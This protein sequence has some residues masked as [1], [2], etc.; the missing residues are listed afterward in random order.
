M[1]ELH[2]KSQTTFEDLPNEIFYEIFDYLDAI[3]LFRSFSN[4]NTRVQNLLGNSSLLLKV[5]ISSMSK[6]NF[7]DYKK[8]IILPCKH[9]IIS[10]NI[11]N[12]FVVDIM[13]RPVR[14]ASQLTRL[15]TVILDNIKSKY[16]CNI[17]KHLA[18]LRNLSSLVLIPIDHYRNTDEIYQC[19]FRLPV[20]KYCKISLKT[21]YRDGLLPIATNITSSIE[22]LVIQHSFYLKD[23]NALLSYVPHVRRLKFHSFHG[24]H[25]N[26]QEIFSCSSSKLTHLS[27]N[28]KS[29]SFDQFELMTQTL[30][31]QLDIIHISVDDDRTYLDAKRWENLILSF[32]PRLRVFDFQ[33]ID[34]IKNIAVDIQSIHEPLLKQFESSFW[35]QRKWF[36]HYQFYSENC[37]KKVI[38]HSVNL[39]RRK[40]YTINRQLTEYVPP[41]YRKTNMDAVNHVEIE[42]E[43]AIM[44]C[45]NYFRNATKLT[46]SQ[47]FGESNFWLRINLKPILPVKRLTT[48][49]INCDYFRLDQL[50]ELLRLAPHVHTLTMN[51]NSIK[52]SNRSSFQ[53]NEAFQFVSKTNN[54]TNVTIKE[55]CASAN[56]QLYIDLCPRMQHLAIEGYYRHTVSNIQSILRETKTNI[57]QLCSICITNVRK[58][59]ITALKTMIESEKILDNYS[60]KLIDYDLYLWW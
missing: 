7:E 27:I 25:S 3:H 43:K 20:L 33:H 9:R 24:S 32:M 60:M 29:V 57:Q 47:C 8:D 49:V 21:H 23:L 51:V 31:R 55:R 41:R 40:Q 13:F 52:Y 10:V 28:L 30:F 26:E 39:Y 42:G 38:L 56:S 2:S 58:S 17:L 6:S 14:L 36:F 50:I 4:L 35:S 53:Q 1:N 11:S 12:P 37:R 45:V 46:L 48:L 59:I 19:I 5:N 16:L 18:S 34:V 22:H 15:K 54:I 44:K